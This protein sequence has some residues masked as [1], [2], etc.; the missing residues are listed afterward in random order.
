MEIWFVGAKMVSSKY[1]NNLQKMIIYSKVW[2]ILKIAVFWYE[3]TLRE[4]K[5]SKN[6]LF[7]MKLNLLINQL[8]LFKNKLKYFI[9][10]I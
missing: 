1:G 2:H 5:M 6:N 4:K 8:S 9:Y 7:K 10:L 3:T